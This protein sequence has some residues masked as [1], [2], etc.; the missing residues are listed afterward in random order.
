MESYSGSEFFN[1]GTGKDVS[2][3]E[4]AEMIKDIVGYTGKIVYD[5]SKPDGMPQKMM[6]C[7]KLSERGWTYQT[8]LEEGLKKT[9]KWYLER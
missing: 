7:S 4:L 6:D 3:G 9:Y 5:T 2:V 8:E 1:V